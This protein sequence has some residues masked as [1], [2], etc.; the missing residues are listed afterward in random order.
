MRPGS[1]TSV[2]MRGVVFLLRLLAARLIW[3]SELHTPSS[4]FSDSFVDITRNHQHASRK[5]K[6]SEQQGLCESGSKVRKWPRCR[7]QQAKGMDVDWRASEVGDS[8]SN[9]S[10]RSTRIPEI[11]L[12]MHGHLHFLA[13]VQQ[14]SGVP[15][16]PGQTSWMKTAAVH[17]AHSH[18]FFTSLHFLQ[19]TKQAGIADVSLGVD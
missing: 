18:T 17:S 11:H 15:D 7:G 2:R 4:P 3:S 9:E 14:Y 10:S 19:L 16:W 1:L 6:S 12:Q 5:K 13:S 8:S